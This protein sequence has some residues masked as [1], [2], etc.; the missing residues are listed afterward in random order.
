[1]DLG[2]KVGKMERV[3]MGLDFIMGSSG[4][5]CSSALISEQLV[6][7][8]AVCNRRSVSVITNQ[9]GNRTTPSIVAFTDEER[10][11][12]GEA[13]NQVGIHSSNTV[14][15]AKR[16][17]GRKFSD[18]SVQSHIKRWPF[19]V[20]FDGQHDKPMIVVE[21]GGVENKYGGEKISS[22]VLSK[23]KEIAYLGH[24]VK[25]SVV[26]V[27]AYFDDTQRRATEDAGSIAG[28]RVLRI[29]NEPTAAALANGLDVRSRGRNGKTKA[30]I[31]DLGGGTLDVS[32][33]EIEEDG[34]LEVMS[35]A[36]DGHLGGNDFDDRMV[37]H[38]AQ[39]FERKFNLDMK[40][41]PKS[42]RRLR[43][44][45]ERAKKTLSFLPRSTIDIDSLYNG[46]DFHAAITTARFEEM[47]S[48]L[49]SK[50]LESVEKCLHHAN[51]DTKN[52][53]DV[54]L[55]G[56]STRIPKIRQLVGDFFHGKQ[57]NISINPDEAVAIGA[58]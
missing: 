40:G 18:E 1:M 19:K 37:D 12:G 52:V 33:V 20:V 7:C 14:F 34:T 28:L 45:C 23:M 16:L 42:L 21:H 24:T 25:D 44:T 4:K 36:G 27:P 54:V 30:L 13:K 9:D 50:C 46:I 8:V 26:T 41:N 38:F 35:T 31:F 6:S 58:A 17:I 5:G 43:S 57:I 15:D 55:V 47:N 2:F 56:G 10:L 11:I 51:I 53:D 48:D 32:L 22:M 3:C 39:E 49:F 29:L